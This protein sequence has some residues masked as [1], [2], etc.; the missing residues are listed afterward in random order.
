MGN[1]G[2]SIFSEVGN[3]ES[4]VGISWLASAVSTAKEHDSHVNACARL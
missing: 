2:G 3:K 4:C 1:T